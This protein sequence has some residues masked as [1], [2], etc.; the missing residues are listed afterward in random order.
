MSRYSRA[1]NDKARSGGTGTRGYRKNCTDDSLDSSPD[2]PAHQPFIRRIYFKRWYRRGTAVPLLSK[3]IS[4]C[5][6]IYRQTTFSRTDADL[7]NGKI[8]SNRTALRVA[9]V[10]IIRYVRFAAKKTVAFVLSSGMLVPESYYGH[11]EGLY[12]IAGVKASE[13]PPGRKLSVRVCLC[14]HP[15]TV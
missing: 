3:G 1:G 5:R 14:A 13:S 12:L 7:Y 2:E 4:L 8:T 11:F 10:Y 9:H 6:K 15:P